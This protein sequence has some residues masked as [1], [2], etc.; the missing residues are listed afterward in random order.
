MTHI[1]VYR[2]NKLPLGICV[3]GHSGYADAGEDI[4]CAGISVLTINFIN[5][6]E[7]FT[8]DKFKVDSDEEGAVIDFKFTDTPSDKSQLLFDSLVLGLRDLQ[9]ENK[10]FISLDSKEV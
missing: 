3:E 4:V 7:S 6:V 1:T 8:D 9:N 10:D 2:T 5:S